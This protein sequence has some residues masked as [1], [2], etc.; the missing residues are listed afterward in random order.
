MGRDVITAM[1]YRPG[2]IDGVALTVRNPIAAVAGTA[3]EAV[4]EVKLFAPGAFRKQRMR[5]VTAKR[6][7]RTGA[8]QQP[9]AARR[10][11][12]ELDRQLV[13]SARRSRSVRHRDRHA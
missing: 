12:S 3:P 9:G 7:R 4:A 2:T 5:A 10:G 11:R 6:L 13:R 8:A 1:V